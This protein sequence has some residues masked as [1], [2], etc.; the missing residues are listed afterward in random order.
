MSQAEYEKQMGRLRRR[1]QMLELARMGSA[2][3]QKVKVR[4]YT[5]K[6]HTVRAHT[7]VYFRNIEES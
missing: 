1:L 2:H 6:Q 7:R 5:V 4:S 3:V